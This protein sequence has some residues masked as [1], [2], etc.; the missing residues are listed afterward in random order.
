M[1]GRKE[2]SIT[3]ATELM[4]RLK[5]IGQMD[6]A[7][8][9]VKM[10]TAEMQQN[11]VRSA[12]FNGHFEW[13]AKKGLVFVKPTGTTKRSIALEISNGGLTGKVAPG[14]N[15]SPFLIYGTRFMA[16]QDFFR[17]NYHKQAIQFKQDMQRLVE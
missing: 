15:Y 14:T 2:I 13:E 16:A 17:P 10:N 12:T 9:I 4:D 7:K 11:M 6:E 3:G 8:R 5:V 1:S